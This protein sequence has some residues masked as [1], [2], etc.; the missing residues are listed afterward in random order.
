MGGWVG[1]WV[2]E[3]SG[4]RSFSFGIGMVEGFSRIVLMS[5]STY[6]GMNGWMDGWMDESSSHSYIERKTRLS[7]HPH[8]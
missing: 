8:E 2:G 3:I 6:T 4:M 5:S 1:G 7:T